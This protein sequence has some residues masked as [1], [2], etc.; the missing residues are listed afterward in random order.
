MNLNDFLNNFFSFICPYIYLHTLTASLQVSEA[1]YGL[2]NCALTCFSLSWSIYCFF[3]QITS[4]PSQTSNEFTSKIQEHSY[5]RYLSLLSLPEAFSKN[6]I[7]GTWAEII[8]H[9]MVS[10]VM[11][12]LAMSLNLTSAA[13][14]L[15]GPSIPIAASSN[16]LISKG[17]TFLWITSPILTSPLNLASFRAW[18][19]LIFLT[20]ISL[21]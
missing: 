3:I 15:L 5:C 11:R 14:I 21:V 6:W 2:C 20:P 12:W 16:S 19:I 1:K 9:G 18:R 10:Y 4:Y 8:A 17:L 7:H 13:A